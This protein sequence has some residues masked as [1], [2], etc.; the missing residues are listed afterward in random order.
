M[1]TLLALTMLSLTGCSQTRQ[2]IEYDPAT[3]QQA[4]FAL[5]VIFVSLA[6]VA[7]IWA[8]AWMIVQLRQSR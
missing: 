4:N 1:K 3:V 6:A 7:A 5:M 2:V 8:I